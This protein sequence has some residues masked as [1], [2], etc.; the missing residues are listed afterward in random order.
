MKQHKD[1]KDYKPVGYCT[2]CGIPVYPA[3]IDRHNKN[4]YFK[5]S[6]DEE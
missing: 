3:N 2:K 4:C 1:Y 5:P 6:T